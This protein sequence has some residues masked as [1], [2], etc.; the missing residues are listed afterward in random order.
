MVS[1][2]QPGVKAGPMTEVAYLIGPPTVPEDIRAIYIRAQEM[3]ANGNDSLARTLYDVRSR[4]IAYATKPEGTQKG[5]LER[6]LEEKL[7]RPLK[8]VDAKVVEGWVHGELVPN[9]TISWT[10]TLLADGKPSSP[11]IT[12]RMIKAIENSL[13]FV[14]QAQWIVTSVR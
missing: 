10:G 8:T 14:F 7:G 2:I 4:T 3:T 13:G 6:I 5:M 1:A 11:I 12:E 9:L